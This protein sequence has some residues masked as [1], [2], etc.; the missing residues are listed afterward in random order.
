MNNLCKDEEKNNNIYCKEELQIIYRSPNCKNPNILIQPSESNWESLFDTTTYVPIL[1]S[2]SKKKIDL[3]RVYE[4]KNINSFLNTTIILIHG[5][6]SCALSW[7][8]LINELQKTQKY[9]YICIDLRGHGHTRHLC[10]DCTIMYKEIYNSIKPLTFKA[11]EKK[12]IPQFSCSEILRDEDQS[13]QQLVK[14]CV[15][16]LLQIYNFNTIINTLF[17][18][19][20][21]GSAIVL[22]IAIAYTNIFKIFGIVVCD[23]YESNL[24]YIENISLN[25]CNTIQEKNFS[26]IQDVQQSYTDLYWDRPQDDTTIISI[27]PTLL[28]V[29]SNTNDNNNKRKLQLRHINRSIYL[30]GKSWF[31]NFYTCLISLP[32]EKLFLYSQNSS[33]YIEYILLPILNTTE[34]FGGL[35]LYPIKDSKHYIHEDSPA[36]V[37]S[38]V[39][40]FCI[41]CL[42]HI[43]DTFD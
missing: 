8:Y 12:Y 27:L 13:Q 2:N 31:K 15:N 30:H 20:S 11:C 14:D 40:S 6:G 39:D 41:F 3:F 7:Y 36:A 28:Y 17:M 32:L 33:S 24:Q 1:S 4:K 25:D 21:V 38:I 18:G 5:I 10:E 43:V 19:H 35:H 16:I 37:A 22:Q 23:F 29:N 9:S 34:H 42:R 26:S